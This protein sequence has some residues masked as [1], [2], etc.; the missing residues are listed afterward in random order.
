MKNEVETESIVH[1]NT[2]LCGKV[3][4]PCQG[5]AKLKK[6]EK[7]LFLE[8]ERKRNKTESISTAVGRSKGRAHLDS[9]VMN[10]AYM[11]DVPPRGTHTH[12]HTR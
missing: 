5:T 7:L 2:S 12:T 3:F 9:W 1:D 6:R 4:Y 11:C 8:N 10:K